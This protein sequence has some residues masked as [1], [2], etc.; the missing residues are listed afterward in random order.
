M[1]VQATDVLLVRGQ[2]LSLPH[3]PLAPY[4]ARLPKRLRPVIARWS[5]ANFRGYVALWEIRD[6]MLWLTDVDAW[7]ELEGETVRATLETFLPHRKGPIP[8]T[9]VT[10]EFRCPEG[11]LRSISVI[12]GIGQTDT[13][14]MRGF[15]VFKGRVE[16]EWV[17]YMPPSP[18]FYRLK[19]D[20]IRQHVDGILTRYGWRV[21]PDGPP[22]P[23]PDGASV[24]PWRLWGDPDH[25][26]L[27]PEQQWGD[28]CWRDG[29]SV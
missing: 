12:R 20:G 5:T 2:Y 22:D 27:P 3:F 9:W 10:D 11:R 25:D 8:A 17:A 16:C 14:R 18:I 4:L 23:F 19:P 24:E 1:T 7:I 29:P 26:I 21:A 6:G 13:E 15:D 28:P